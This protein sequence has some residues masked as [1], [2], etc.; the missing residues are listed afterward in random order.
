MG[1]VVG[2]WRCLEQQKPLIAAFLGAFPQGMC[3]RS[4]LPVPLGLAICSQCLCQHQPL[5][6]EPRKQ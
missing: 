6:P 5:A 1:W 3:E 4:P 2:A